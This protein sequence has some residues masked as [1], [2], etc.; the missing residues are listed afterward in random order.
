MACY[1]PVHGYR[2]RLGGFTVSRPMAYLDRPMKVPCGQC[3]G[4]RLE[5]SRQWAM[6]CMHEAEHHAENSYITLT[7][8]E[9]NLPLDGSVNVEIFQKFMKKLRK[10]KGNVRYFHCG[11]YGDKR[12]RPHY[13]ALLFGLDFK[14][15]RPWKK[16]ENGDMLYT[17]KELDCIWS[18]GFCSVGSVSFQSAAYVARYV[19]KKVTAKGAFTYVRYDFRSKKFRKVNPEYGTMSRNPGLGSQW[20]TENEKQVYPRDEVI[21]NGAISK[22]P[23][24]YDEKI[25]KRDAGEKTNN[26]PIH[27]ST[28]ERTRGERRRDGKKREPD[29]TPERL[30]VREKV[31]RAKL[32]L[33][34]RNID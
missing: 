8:D 23:R 26:N 27:L 15:K 33:Y 1:S 7:Y 32:N 24:Y 3:I 34:G 31:T 20:I 4:C 19:T 17:S 10:R 21:I 22:P 18:Y 2:S 12:N 13:H 28:I 9:K 11:E 16:N 25:E 30:V 29:N 6:R 14:D 5:H